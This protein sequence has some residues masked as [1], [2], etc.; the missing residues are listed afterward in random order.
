ME[1][2][3]I[4]SSILLLFI[5]LFRFFYFSQVS[6]Q[7]LFMN[8]FITSEFFICWHVFSWYSLTILFIYISSSVLSFILDFN[9]L[10]LLSLPLFS[11]L[12]YVQFYQFQWSFKKSLVSS[13]SSV[14]LLV[15]ILFLSTLVLISFLLLDLDLVFS[16]FSS[17]PKLKIRLLIWGL[18]LWIIVH[19]YKFSSEHCFSCIR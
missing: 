5:H 14:I 16:S 17:F 11:W 19:S 13:I 18:L 10:S 1:S 9:N 12:V 7:C 8:L 6:N 3:K 4:I 15:F 2:F